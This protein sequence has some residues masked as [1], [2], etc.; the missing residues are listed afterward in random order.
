MGG[1]LMPVPQLPPDEEFFWPLPAAPAFAP[2]G[3][4]FN[5]S[6][7]AATSSTTTLNS[8]LTKGVTVSKSLL[9]IDSVDK[10]PNSVT[11]AVRDTK[12]L[13]DSN[14]YSFGTTLFFKPESQSATKESSGGISFF[15]SEDG[16]T[17]YL[18]H[19]K[20]TGLAAATSSKSDEFQILKTKYDAATNKTILS[21]IEDSQAV[22]KTSKVTNILQGTS[23]KIDVNVEVG[24][25]ITKITAFVNGFKIT[26]EDKTAPRLSKSSKIGLFCSLGTIGFDYVYARSIKE[27]EYK[28]NLVQ[29]LYKTQ[30]AN[31]AR[32]FLYGDLW[33]S[34]ISQIQKNDKNI[35]MEEF[36]PVAR[37]IKYIDKDYS[38]QPAAAKYISTN[39][40]QY[41]DIIGSNLTPFNVKAYIIN[42][43]STFVPI[44]QTTVSKISVI[45]NNIIN[46]S[47]LIYMDESLNKYDTQEPITFDSKWIQR[48]SEAKD[49]SDW[50]KT[51]WKNQQISLNLEVIANPKIQIGDIISVDYA[52]H[53]LAGTEKFIVNSISQTWNGGIKTT[54]QARSIYSE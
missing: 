7:P 45:G 35:W 37:E 25:T 43:S 44:N 12:I 4:L 27:V 24:T 17:G 11:I 49:L 20:T 6:D 22:T 41:V 46:S 5:S 51:Q 3:S 32:I 28:S 48:E 36:G 16:K 10:D 42:N 34:G 2:K 19:I 1:K 18:I 38:T 15:A 54:I 21:R 40:N 39:I 8:D 26:A 14:Y 30:F 33:L 50:I 13:T 47:G 29:E 52:Y 9:M 23:Y 53:D 31:M